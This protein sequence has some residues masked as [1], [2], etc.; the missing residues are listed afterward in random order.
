MR[1]KLPLSFSK[2][3]SSASSASLS[4]AA[5]SAS[6]AQ[7]T[8]TENCFAMAGYT[9]HPRFLGDAK[10]QRGDSKPKISAKKD[11]RGTQT[12]EVKKRRKW[13]DV[14]G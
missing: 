4:E 3:A 12:R 1:T 14:T 9:P 5:S 6:S 10:Q 8:S 2:A 13:L 11:D 7:E